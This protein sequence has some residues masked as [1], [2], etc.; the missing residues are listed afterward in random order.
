M[1]TSRLSAKD[2]MGA[3]LATNGDTCD[4]LKSSPKVLFFAK[5]VWQEYAL[6]MFANLVMSRGH[7]L[8]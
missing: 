6:R 2:G 7:S 1:K 3:K 5:N 8:A 4:V